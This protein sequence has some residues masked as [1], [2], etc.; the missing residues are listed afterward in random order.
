MNNFLRGLA[1]ANTDSLITVNSV[2][3]VGAHLY[4]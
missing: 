2:L 4:Q 3:I 1:W